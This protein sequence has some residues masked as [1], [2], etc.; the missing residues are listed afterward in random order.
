MFFG[1]PVWPCKW[2]PPYDDAIKR[3]ASLGF[4]GVELIAWSSSY[5]RISAT[6]MA[7][8][9]RTGVRASAIKIQHRRSI[10]S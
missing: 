7:K 4:Q 10:V 1:A 3:I 8:P 9:M 2:H 5:T 6:T